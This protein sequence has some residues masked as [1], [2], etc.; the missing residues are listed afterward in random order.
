MYDTYWLLL[1]INYI[2]ALIWLCEAM[3]RVQWVVV[4][5]TLS[6]TTILWC[7]VSCWALSLAWTTGTSTTLL[8]YVQS[9]GDIMIRMHGLCFHQYADSLQLTLWRECSCFGS[10]TVW[11][12]DDCLDDK[13]NGWPGNVCAWMTGLT[14]NKL[15]CKSVA[16]FVD[17]S[18]I[19]VGE[20]TITAS[21][22]FI[23]K[24]KRR[25]VTC[26]L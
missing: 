19:R 8:A 10:S 14:S 17:R 22:C 13:N 6:S 23:P 9:T 3:T 26:S 16:A 20:S 4:D 21:R 18:M 1:L 12:M 11:Q 7:W 5:G 2:T 24:I 25:L 15:V